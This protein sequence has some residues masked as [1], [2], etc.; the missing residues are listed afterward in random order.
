MASPHTAPAIALPTWR[1]YP[2]GVEVAPEGLVHARVWAPKR[3]RVAVVSY[4]P[5]GRVAAS[6]VLDPEGNGYFSGT[7]PSAGAGTLYK[8]RLDDAGDF[9]DPASRFQPSGPHGPS[10]VIDSVRYAWRDGGWSGVSLPGQVLY[11][12]HVGTFTAEGTYRAAVQ[13]LGELAEVGV[14]V[15]ELMPV[16]EFP[17]RF[18][19]GYDGVQLFA[20]YHHYGA[21]DDLRSFIDAA[22]DRGIAVLLDVVYNHLGPDGNC[23]KEFSDHYFKGQTE[24][25][26]ALNFDGEHSESVR[27]LYL[28]NAQYWTE[29]FHFDGLRLDATQQIFDDSTP[30]IIAEIAA[31]VREAGKERATLLVAEN[32][33]Q[34]AKLVRPKRAGGHG[35][36]ALW[37]DDFHHSAMVA[38]TGRAEAYYS[39]YRGSAQEFVSTAKYGFLYQ[40]EWYEWQRGRRGT[41]AYDIAPPHF[42]N[43][44]QNHDQI[45]NAAGGLRC[46]QLSSP[47]RYRAMTAL[48]LLLPQTP[49]L[50]Q[51]QEFVSSSPFLY[52]GD[53]KPELASL[54]RRGR[55]EFL[56][57]FASVATDEMAARLADPSSAET[58]GR[59]KIDWSER[60]RG[61]HARALALVRDLLRLRRE[62]D[63][64]RGQAARGAT[65]PSTANGGA[66]DG[67]VLDSSAFFLRYFGERPEL[68]RLVVVN[69]G[70]ATHA[71]PLAEP[72]VAPIPGAL[73]R[74]IWSSEAA[75]YGGNGTPTVDSDDG[76]W[77]LPAEC[78]LVLAPVSCERAAAAPRHAS[79]EK[80]ARAQWKDRHET[81]AG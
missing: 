32:E 55:A 50:F 43:F 36:D 33:P 46:H 29:E 13:H 1:R 49:M 73:W 16:A 53:H 40:G 45:A 65:W 78:T 14:T 44:T 15:I 66:I 18:G 41:P 9:P 10:Q 12:L 19:W 70:A 60:S 67:A 21:P 24:W 4:A 77:W 42:V 72:L 39:G 69:F 34:Q 54:V 81:I 3:R 22:H 64:L 35:L 27:E 26:D 47:A 17:G 59:C 71:A 79:S 7:V 52:F 25:G 28:T 57:Q 11:E 80:E 20:P 37:N 30:H 75:V 38:L 62:D 74:P 56:G 51:G 31:R 48:L 8:F 6:E 58:F 61:D 63:T 5:D 76:G 68:D 2:I 23:L